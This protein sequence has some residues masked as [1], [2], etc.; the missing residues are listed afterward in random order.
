[1]YQLFSL[2][3]CSIVQIVSCYMKRVP[4]LWNCSKQTINSAN[5]T[6]TWEA[7]MF[8]HAWSISVGIKVIY[9]VWYEL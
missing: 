9:F 8:S 1:M 2:M 4:C 6:S 7:M 3:L 5:M